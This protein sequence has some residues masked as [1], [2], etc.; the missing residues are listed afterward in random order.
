MR[1]SPLAKCVLGGILLIGSL[2]NKTFGWLRGFEYLQTNA[3]HLF[4]FL[5]S[6]AAEY[7]LILAGLAL[8]AV[9]AYEVL[10]LKSAAGNTSD[11]AQGQKPVKVETQ[12]QNSPIVLGPGPTAI[13]YHAAAPTGDTSMPIHLSTSGLGNNSFDLG[14]HP[15][16]LTL[17]RYGLSIESK[18]S[19]KTIDVGGNSVTI[20]FQDRYLIVNDRG[21]VVSLDGTIFGSL[22]RPTRIAR[23]R[24]MVNEIHN[25]VTDPREIVPAIVAHPDFP[26]LRPH[27]GEKSRALCD[28]AID[29]SPRRM[30]D[31]MAP[32][33]RS[34]LDDVDKL[35]K[36]WGTD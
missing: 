7:T 13:H 33:L 2:L 14:L 21:Q 29:A 34:L 28:G 17:E 30:G 6:P 27:L 31:P 20:S 9:G 25:T 18:D 5:V 36:E 19:P 10:L 1:I 11:D 16:K 3:P 8:S 26:S 4:A 32:I 22:D 35:A 24:A 23:W 12:G 15:T